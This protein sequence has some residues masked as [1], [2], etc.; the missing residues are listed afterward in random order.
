MLTDIS[1]HALSNAVLQTAWSGA[2]WAR[3]GELIRHTTAE[4]WS[5]GDITQFEDMLR[6]VYLPA[7]KNGDT[8]ASNWDVGKQ[9]LFT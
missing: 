6:N 4:L 1:A 3:A 8:R 9:S 7:V 5:S 2:S